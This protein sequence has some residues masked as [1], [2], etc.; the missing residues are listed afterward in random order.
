MRV[1][2]WM[3]RVFMCVRVFARART[4]ARHPQFFSTFGGNPVACAAGNAVM[5]VIEAENLQA[6]AERVGQ[7][8]KAKLEGLADRHETIGDVRGRGLFLGIDFVTDRDTRA[9][10]VA[11]GISKHLLDKHHILSS[12]DGW[13]QNVMGNLEQTKN[14]NERKKW[15]KPRRHPPFLDTAHTEWM[16]HLGRDRKDVSLPPRS[17]KSE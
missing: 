7:Y 12:L 8:L 6:R 16:T 1:D 2:E 14:F 10:G 4:H 13:A 3:C 11:S 9:P 15:E 5:D 17:G